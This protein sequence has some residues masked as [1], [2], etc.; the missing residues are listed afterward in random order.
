MHPLTQEFGEN[1]D[2]VI[3]DDNPAN[4][5]LLSV[6]L[7]ESG[8]RVRT[9]INAR[10]ALSA[11][12]AQQPDLV[13]LDITMPDINGIELCR[14]L[15]SDPLFVDLPI[16]FLSALDS[17]ADKS[18]AF[19]LGGVDYITKPFKPE[20]ILLRARTHLAIGRLKRQLELVN[21][22]LEERVLL[23]TRQLSALNTAYATFFPHECLRL[24]GKVDILELQLGDHVERE[25]T[26]LFADIEGFTTLAESMAPPAIFALINDYLSHVGP[27][28]REHGGFIDKYIG[29]AIMA[30]FLRPNDAV[31]ASVALLAALGEFNRKQALAGEGALSVGI[32][33]HC[34]TVSFGILGENQRMQGTVIG[35]AVNVAA[36]IEGLT[37]AYGAGILISEA[38][39][40]LVR[41][42]ASWTYRLIDTVPIRGRRGSTVVW[43]VLAPAVVPEHAARVDQIETYNRGLQAFDRGQ[44]AEAEQLFRAVLAVTP[45]DQASR[46]YL[47]RA[48]RGQTGPA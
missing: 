28:V 41:D 13:I 5:R 11:I 47:E 2:I 35:D 6:V 32:G 4:L 21:R 23:R 46:S 48:L 27:V 42:D 16:I 29:D 17:I 15:R 9:A 40:A 7:R 44:W 12:R 1:G 38:A 31:E 19:D 3:V 43:E 37:R 10:I 26:I 39:K 18:E 8:H 36:R 22:E 45:E 20:E 24:L 34:G 33:V 14:I 25:M 30:L